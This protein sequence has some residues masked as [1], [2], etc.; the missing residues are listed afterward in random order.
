MICEFALDP[1]LV[2]TWHDRKEYLFF[3]EKFGVRTGRIVSLYPKKW[4]ALV[5][6]RFE[7]SP[8]GQ[9][10]N[11]RKNLTA[12]LT[13]LCQHAVKRRSSFSEIEDWLE[14]AEAEHA[15]RPFHGILSA[16]NPRHH[17]CVIHSAELT[18]TCHALW[19][20][21]DAP[22]VS[23]NVRDLVGA[24]EPLLKVCR[25]A[26]FVDPYFDPTKSR[27]T[28]PF[29]GYMEAVWT[30]RYGV[31]DPIVELHTGIDRFFRHG[32]D[33]S[34]DEE[35]RVARNLSGDMKRQ[36]PRCI[37]EGKTV[38]VFIWKQRE[39]GERLHNRYILSEVAGV[40][41]GTGLDQS[42]DPESVE[43]DD[44]SLLSPIQLDTRWKQYKALPSA[45]EPIE[46]HPII[47]V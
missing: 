45:F 21:P 19:K 24:V 2:A 44:I 38:Q 1:E 4:P 46:V 28:D 27:F 26:V 34:A 43:T 30:S 7:R 17:E 11:A 10:Q 22:V 13:D 12:L 35:K 25:H 31:D 42:N 29:T 40:S 18:E 16:K 39:H 37:P 23:R 20:V 8:C 14:R 41:F 3:D 36:L 32:E 6:K 15:E 33:R 5:W 9:D 47:I